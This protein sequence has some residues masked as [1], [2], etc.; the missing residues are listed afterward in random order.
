[1]QLKI[2]GEKMGVEVFEMGTS[3]KPV[4]IAKAAVEYAKK[5]EFNVLFIDT[6]GRLHVDEEMMAELVEI[7]EATEESQTS[8]LLVFSFC[9]FARLL[10]AFDVLIYGI[11]KRSASIINIAIPTRTPIHNL[12][13]IL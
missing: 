13:I 7:K 6:A 2:N 10:T 11:R 5:N 8:I 4:N 12:I 9:C 3:E 1:E